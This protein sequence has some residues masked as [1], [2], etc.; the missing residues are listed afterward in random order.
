M[1]V[2][3]L[4]ADIAELLNAFME[5]VRE[6]P[7]IGTS[8]IS[9]Y[10]TLVSCWHEKHFEYPL[11][12]F[13]RELMPLCKIS[14]TGTY[15]RCIRELHEYGYISYQPSYNHFLGSLVYFNKIK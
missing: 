7:R 12:V 9:L 4:S 6:D 1:L 5:A 2:P 8:H 15:H 10:V 14:G 3:V 11:S 13:A